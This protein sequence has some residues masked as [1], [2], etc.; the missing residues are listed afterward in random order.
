MHTKARGTIYPNTNVKRFPVPDDMVPWD[1]PFPGYEPVKFTSQHILDGPVYADPDIRNPRGR[2]GITGRGALGRWGPNHAGDP[3]VTRWKHTSEGHKFYKNDKPILEFVAIK[4][5]DNGQWAIP[6]GMVDPGDSVSNTLRKEFGEEA[7][8]SMEASEEER[9]E[10]SNTVN[11]L[12]KGGDMIYKGYVDDP[13]NTDNAWMETIAVNFHDDTGKAF[14]RVTLEAGDD[15]GA[16]KWMAIS[17]ELNLY[18]N[19]VDMIYQ[20]VLLHQ[21][22]LPTQNE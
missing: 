20:A 11:E 21:A 1:E 16:V 2:T 19:H 7:L 3:I 4:R 17:H 8:N 9:K 22:Y 10:L 14:D 12:F 6:G 15:A 5:R 13:R 18:A